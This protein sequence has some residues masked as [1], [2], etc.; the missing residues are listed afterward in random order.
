MKYYVVRTPILASTLQKI[1][2][3][4][5]VFGANKIDPKC[6]SNMMYVT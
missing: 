1:F 4:L 5:D 6:F 3:F 2:I